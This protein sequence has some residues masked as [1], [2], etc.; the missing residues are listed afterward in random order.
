MKAKG[1]T[2]IELIIVIAILAILAGISLPLYAAY[3]S[4]AEEAVAKENAHNAMMRYWADNVPLGDYNANFLYK[5]DDYRIVAIKNGVVLP[6]IFDKEST[7]IKAIVD[8]PTT[9]DDESVT[10][11]AVATGVEKLYAVTETQGNSW[12][13]ATAYF[14]GDSITAGSNIS[15]KYYEHIGEILGLQSANAYGIGGSCIS[16]QSD[17]GT[18]NTPLIN[19]FRSIPSVDLIVIFMGTN[20]YG[21]ETPLGTMQDSTDISFYGAL[22][23]IIPG[24][25]EHNPNSQL[26]FVTPMHRYGFGTSKITGTKFTDDSLPNGRGHSLADYVNAIKSVCA[27]Y[28]VPVIDLFS[29]CPINPSIKSDKDVY[30]PDGL[31]PNDAGHAVI[32]KVLAEQ[33][34]CYPNKNS[35]SSAGQGPAAAQILMQ[36]GNK[37]SSGYANNTAR[38]SSSVNLYLKAGQTVTLKNPGLF[39]WALAKT[40]GPDSSNNEGYYPSASGWTSISSYTIQQDGYYGVTIKKKDNNEFDFASGMDFQ[41][42]YDYVTV[43]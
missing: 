8:D 36:Y 33:L 35:Q 15:K 25:Q 27:K 18:N 5:E 2:L 34:Q 42:L 12:E 21:H 29:I 6:Q 16:A 3:I 10:Y 17:Y 1:F 30:F 14:V 39:E 38:I 11:S 43:N 22:N 26:I 24:I 32:A 31:H 40:T 23:V 19:R 37:F 4:K 13:G 9:Q 41:N 28:G 7:A 20:D